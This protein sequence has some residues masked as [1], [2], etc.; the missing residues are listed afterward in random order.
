MGELTRDSVCVCVCVCVCVRACVC[1]DH[2]P[3]VSHLVLNGLVYEQR[4]P[5]AAVALSCEEPEVQCLTSQSDLLL[6]FVA[7]T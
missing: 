5:Q 6:P 2:D 3:A 1:E 4:H 7:S